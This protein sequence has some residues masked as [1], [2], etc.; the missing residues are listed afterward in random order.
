MADISS[1]LR[2]WSTTAASN[3]PQGGTTIGGGLDD[4]L[5]A[6]QQVV[7]Q[8]LASQGTNMASAA[9][10]DLA[11]ADGYYI[12]VTGTTTT[13]ALGTEPAGV[14]YWIEAEGAWPITHNATS[15]ILL[16]GASIT[17]AAGDVLRFTSE[18]SGNWR[19]TAHFKANGRAVVN[20]TLAAEQASTSG[21]SIDFTG[22][23]AGTKKITVMLSGVSTDGTSNLLVQIGDA[24]GFETSTYVSGAYD[25]VLA[26]STA[27]FILTRGI[28]AGNTFYGTI[29]LSLE[30]SSA[31]TWVAA[32]T[33]YQA[34]SATVTAAGSKS[35]SAE[36]TQVRITTVN[37][38]DAF[39]AGVINI[40]Y[41]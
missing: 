25:G 15:L 18:G 3:Q 13:T 41:Q 39:D 35:L 33:L 5:R 28:T 37:G 31:F 1:T 40:S 36:L 32:A 6:I 19:Q 22:I 29:T 30:N 21:T 8:F 12:H 7:R 26:T 23:P 16:G 10:L 4:N 9:T 20:I 27:G 38:T 2:A 14:S 24:G 17:C 34:A 11:T